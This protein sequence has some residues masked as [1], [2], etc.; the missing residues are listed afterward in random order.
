LQLLRVTIWATLAVLV[1]VSL[2]R[3]A[4]G[5][6]VPSLRLDLG[7]DFTGAGLVTSA[8]A[9]GLLITSVAAPFIGARLGLRRMAVTAHL[10][11]ALGFALSATSSS[12]VALVVMRAISGLGNGA[13]LVAALQIAIDRAKPEQRTQVSA[14]AWSG[15][16]LGL[17]LAAFASPWLHEPLTW[18]LACW[19]S[20]ALAL[21]VAL[22]VPKVSLETA[23]SAPTSTSATGYRWEPSALI[24]SAY[25]LFG[26]GFIAYT[27]FAA[28]EPSHVKPFFRFL[29]IGV[30]AIIGSLIASRVRNAERAMGVTLFLGSVGAASAIAGFPAGDI[31]FGIGLTAVPGLATAVLR[32][33]AGFA[34][35]TRA[36]ALSAIA[37]G[38][39]QFLGPVFAGIAARQFGIAWAFAIAGAAYGVGVLLVT[40]DQLISRNKA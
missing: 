35:A 28:L 2:A 13:G 36:I 19:L 16:G 22:S 9:V 25:L 39:G 6:I 1:D 32:A 40:L 21:V 24:L 37:V 15:G 14:L 26:A 38:L 7:I 29:T 5:V 10:V 30:S 11:A 20:G 23:V 3:V 17:I 33:R 4:F 12:L 18:R 8:N 31:L 27:T 34:G